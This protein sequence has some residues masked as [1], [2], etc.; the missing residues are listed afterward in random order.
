MNI[1][2]SIVFR[3]VAR[4]ACLVLIA[5]LLPASA[6]MAQLPISFEPG[7]P[8]PVLSGSVI[9][10]N[11]GA[12]GQWGQVY[13][14]RMAP[15]GNI[16]FLDSA[17]SNLYQIA[18]GATEPTLVVGPGPNSSGSNSCATLDAAGNYYNAGIA[19]DSANNLFIGNR[20]SSIATFCR[21]PYTAATNSWNFQNA[22]AWGPPS[23]TSGGS[24]SVLNPQDI[25]IVP[26]SSSCTTNTMFFSTS[27]AAGGDA[28]YEQTFDVATGA[29]GT[30]TPVITN[31]Q[32]LA[33][34][35]VVDHGGNI[36]FTENIYPT[37]VKQRVP[38]ILEVPAGVTGLVANGKGSEVSLSPPISGTTGSSASF[39]GI[40][41]IAVDAQG[42]L[43]FGSVNNAS[44]NGYVD[45]I[46]MIPN[47]GTPTSPSLN[48][49]DTVMVSPVSGSHEPL[50]DPRGFLWLATGGSSNW[51]PT[52]TLAPTC[53]TT[54]TQTI[55]ATCLES[56]IVIW[57]P[58]MGNSGLPAAGGSTSAAVTAY[59]VPAAGGTLVL[60]ANNSFKEN[61][62]VAFS[63]TNSSD[64][65]YPLNGLSFS[66]L[67]SS[68][69][70]TQ[71]A[72]STSDI[73]G[74]SSGATSAVATST[75]YSTVYYT[76]NAA[77]TPANFSFGLG[78]NNFKV[79]GNPTPDTSL[80]TPVPPC[81]A[82]ATYPAFSATEETSGNPS[83]DYSWCSLFVQLNSQAPGA[84]ENDVQMLDSSNAVITGS[85]AF[86]GGVV[87]GAAI[88]SLATP[89]VS[90][91]VSS[92]LTTPGQ[93]AVD[94]QGGMY[95]ADK[96]LKAIEYYPAGT[97][98]ATS[99]TLALGKGLLAPTGVAVDGAGDVFIGDSGSI[100]E[101]PYINGKLQTQ[102]TLASGLGSQLSLAVNTMGD[103]FVA[104]QT[105][106]QVVEIPNPQSAL[107]RQ[108][109]PI[110]TLGASAN[111]SAPS[112]IATDNSGNLWVAD[113]TNL[114]EITMPFG[115]VASSPA[116]TKLPSGVTGLAIDPSG[117]I[118][119]SSASGVYWI[120]TQSSGLDV[121]GEVQL[122]STLGSGNAA[123]VGVALDGSENVYADY[124]SS[125]HAGMAQLS[126]N[127][128][129]NFNNSYSEMNPA[130]PYEVDAQLFN[131]GNAPL[132]LAAFANDSIAQTN[133][134]YSV[135]TA[136][137]NTPAC[138]PSTAVE[139]GNWCYLGL[140]LLDGL[141]PPAGIGLTNGTA[142]VVSDA[143]N[144]PAS[145]SGLSLALA[146]TI[147]QDY[148]PAT[149][150]TVAFAP[151]TT[152]AGCAGGT[153]PGCQT[154]T[155]TVNAVDSTDYGTPSLG[156][157]I[158]EVPGSGVGQSQ[159]SVTLNGTN[160]A[161]FPLA[162]LSGG[163]YNVLATYGGTGAA[164]GTTLNSCQS[165]GC[166]AGSALTTS[167]TINTATPVFAV[168][169]PGTE[170]CLS[171]TQTNCT[172]DPTI[173]QSYLGT[174]FV[175]Y[176]KSAWITS[177]VT[178]S[179]G[180][181][182]G[183]VSFQVNGK[184]VDSTQSLQL[185]G[186]RRPRQLLAGQPSYGRLHAHRALQG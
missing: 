96:G 146:A 101:L 54:S 144:A 170:G 112:A 181:P 74:G 108:G 131:L 67:A 18:P 173:V 22:A 5:G 46:F 122:V 120:P 47:E 68:L 113:G 93:V 20:Y 44:Y 19:F 179:V 186:R 100:Y 23:I 95:V 159:Q 60:T 83:S 172:P 33:A 65:L 110:L 76:F 80:T 148:R 10:F 88:S 123:P 180:T 156:E 29:L 69:S 128:S 106:A 183:C 104:D 98:D 66:V 117:S 53:D 139:P 161:T 32:D 147:T 185:A 126:I 84:V 58:G 35:I 125:T 82:G 167:F 45:G 160:V 162:N 64:P 86:V 78:K 42:N 49:D 6:A 3:R 178:S 28:I 91:I 41:G 174:D 36:Y 38:G 142:T 40:G 13:S 127:G 143:T 121:N 116:T 71:F 92:G 85:N 153:Y 1:E 94:A 39:T 59:S 138:S 48:W 11:H 43:Y 182:T 79:I 133:T 17:Q 155:V 140:S 37:P 118:F 149:S 2:S 52:G 7:N 21:I 136:Q 51:S 9:P 109:L 124:G 81:T 62:V 168:G 166:F 16:L 102:T 4:I 26:C 63:V 163:T 57:K 77:T 105:K 129:I 175:Q 73:A 14:I 152:S 141:T 157:V 61:Q 90:T 137:L 111:F 31:L 169:P 72:V 135:V 15:S 184:P 176:T 114:W 8:P 97:T 145:P 34:S 164:V 150:I 134:E 87:P 103:L 115:G 24:T 171:W 89:T 25:F 165:P 99:G 177:S 119:V 151:N 107:L 56:T 130:V 75:P 12:T 154:V 30:L 55:E 158:L 70:S 50:V 132:T 27:G